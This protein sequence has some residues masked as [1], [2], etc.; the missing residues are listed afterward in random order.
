MTH[1]DAVF[2]ELTLHGQP[3]IL[4]CHLKYRAASAEV[5]QT[6]WCYLGSIPIHESDMKP[7]L[8]LDSIHRM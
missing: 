3:L 4:N 7:N 1:L 8:H 2:T 6:S 5:P